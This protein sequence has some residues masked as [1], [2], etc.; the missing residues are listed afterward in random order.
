MTVYPLSYVL[1][2]VALTGLL[3]LAAGYAIGLIDSAY[4]HGRNRRTGPRA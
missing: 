2:F 3:G 4:I 1:A